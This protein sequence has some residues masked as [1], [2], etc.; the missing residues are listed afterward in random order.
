[1]DIF[2]NILVALICLFF[3]YFLGSI[4]FSILIGR[5]FFHQDPRDFGSKN[6]GATNSGRLWGKKVGLLITILDMLK[7]IIPM[8]ICWGILT[9]VPFGSKPLCVSTELF[10][11]DMVFSYVIQ[12]PVYLLANCG[13]IIGHC[14][15][16]FS[17]FKGG[18]GVSAFMGT[19]LGS[20]WG[21]GWIPAALFYFQ[22][23]KK[24]KYV[25]ICSICFPLI[26]TVFSWVW[27]ILVMTKIIP[28]GYEWFV[29]Y[30]PTINCSWHYALMVTFMT[31]L[32]IWRHSE[33]IKRVKM[34]KERK[35]HW[36]K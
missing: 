21:L 31:I 22:F 14:W 20:S 25:S 36:M 28:H 24:T 32:I 35:I 9:F 27:A 6:A 2:I 12:W 5:T 17:K 34:G 15:P 11:T 29:M 10:Y 33:N 8:W 7:T 23:L 3:G 18:K 13:A 4:S 16:I 1:M 26:A 30:G 19:L